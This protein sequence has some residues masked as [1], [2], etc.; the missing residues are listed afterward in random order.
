MTSNT[1][2][3]LDIPVIDMK[4]AA[5]FYA[6]VLDRPVEMVEMDDWE[7]AVLPGTKEGGVSGCLAPSDEENQPSRHGPLPYLS[8]P[9]RLDEAVRIAGDSGGKIL[10]APHK[11]GPY[12][13]RA[14]ILDTEGNRIAL[15]SETE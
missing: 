9:G 5:D 3:W 14:V 10:R 13:Y 15:H 7:Y 6:K 8:V 4:R 2:V 11:I 1:L 12:G